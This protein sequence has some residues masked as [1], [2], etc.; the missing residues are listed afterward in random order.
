MSPEFR[1]GERVP[2]EPRPPVSRLPI[3]EWVPDQPPAERGAAYD[4][5]RQWYRFEEQAPSAEPP[6]R[7]GFQDHTAR[8]DYYTGG[9]HSFDCAPDAQADGDGGQ[10]D[11]PRPME[12]ENE[13]EDEDEGCPVG[14]PGCNGRAD[15]CHDTCE[16]PDLSVGSPY[17]A[18]SCLGEDEEGDYFADRAELRRQDRQADRDGR[19]R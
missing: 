3:T 16:A 15:Q 13:H 2:Q 14:D 4:G 7:A 19:D 17:D 5:E 18:E 6:E 1:A 10:P 12:W 9:R 8:R 11:R